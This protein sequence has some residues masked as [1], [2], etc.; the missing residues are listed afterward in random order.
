[1]ES[2]NRC[3]H[4]HVCMGK[5][6]TPQIICAVVLFFWS[7]SYFLVSFHEWD[8]V[9]LFSSK[10]YPL[11]HKERILFP[12]LKFLQILVVFT[13]IWQCTVTSYY[14]RCNFVIIEVELDNKF[15][16]KE[17]MSRNSHC[18]VLILPTFNLAISLSV[19]LKVYSLGGLTV[20]SG[21]VSTSSKSRISCTTYCDT[22]MSRTMA[23]IVRFPFRIGPKKEFW[24]Q[25]WNFQVVIT[26]SFCGCCGLSISSFLVQTIKIIR[27]PNYYYRYF[28]PLF[29]CTTHLSG[30]FEIVASHHRFLL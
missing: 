4:G 11:R 9:W 27:T 16:F 13:A 14:Y 18:I 8:V 26:S 29:A 3:D 23:S 19:T 6:S 7:L 22:P 30:F 15:N 5:T 21:T 1:M 10:K 24:K 25:L 2:D 12:F 17:E 28:P 20:T